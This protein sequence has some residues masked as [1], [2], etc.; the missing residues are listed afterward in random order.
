[1]IPRSRERGQHD[2]GIA[3]LRS[4]IVARVSIYKRVDLGSNS[5]RAKFC[6]NNKQV[7][8]RTWHF[9]TR[10]LYNLW[11]ISTDEHIYMPLIFNYEMKRFASRIRIWNKLKVVSSKRISIGI[12][13]KSLGS[14]QRW[15]WSERGLKRAIF[16][17]PSLRHRLSRPQASNLQFR[18]VCYCSHQYILYRRGCVRCSCQGSNHNRFTLD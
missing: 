3:R 13:P 11:C 18:T 5:I 14:I 16:N 15:F 8:K 6:W 1:M 12:L 9:D 10:I 2:D 4:C 7:T 17:K